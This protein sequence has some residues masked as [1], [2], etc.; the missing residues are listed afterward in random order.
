MGFIVVKNGEKLVPSTEVFIFR[1]TKNGF[2]KKDQILAKMNS[3]Q[4][5]DSVKVD[6]LSLV[7]LENELLCNPYVNSA[8]AF[9]NLDGDLIINICEKKPLVRIF[10]KNSAGYY[11]TENGDILPLSENYSARVFMCNG[12]LN[13][14]FVDGNTKVTD[15]TYSKTALADILLL[16][17]TLSENNFLKS[18]VNQIY[19][20]SKKEFELISEF[21][22][23]TIVV[24]DLEKLDKKFQKLEA[25]YTQALIEEGVGKYKTINLKFD[26]QVVCTKKK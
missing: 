19:I 3:F 7:G 4:Q 11:L 22:N 2:L 13:I 21:D 24:G 8:D 20:N 5:L 18:Q 1:E 16:S 15:S 25:F 6:E 9:T 17:N 26:G 12:Y 14:P 10:N 23:H